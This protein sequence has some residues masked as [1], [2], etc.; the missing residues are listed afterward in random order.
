MW[1]ILYRGPRSSKMV[2]VGLGQK[3]NSIYSMLKLLKLLKL[4]NAN[5]V[6]CVECLAPQCIAVDVLWNW[7]MYIGVFYHHIGMYWM[8]WICDFLIR[9][10]FRLL[11]IQLIDAVYTCCDTCAI[12]FS[13]RLDQCAVPCLGDVFRW[14]VLPGLSHEIFVWHLDLYMYVIDCNCMYSVSQCQTVI[15][16]HTSRPFLVLR[17][18]ASFCVWVHVVISPMTWRNGKTGRLKDLKDKPL[19]D[20][21][22]GRSTE[23]TLRVCDPD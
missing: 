3:E 8:C 18:H 23:A 21:R 14:K 6:Q 10:L 9:C 4:L 19:Q 2:Q 5:N 1:L 17:F 13:S 22:H 15:C 7:C 12:S 20:L 11:Y 16:L